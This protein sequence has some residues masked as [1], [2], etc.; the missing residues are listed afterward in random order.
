MYPFKIGM[1]F[2]D[3]LRQI[4]DRPVA[5]DGIGDAAANIFPHLPITID[6][7]GVDGLIRFGPGLPDEPFYLQELSFLP[8]DKSFVVN[9]IMLYQA[10]RLCR[11]HFYQK[12]HKDSRV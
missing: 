6:Q 3:E 7:F 11:E 4:V 5:P 2:F 12:T 1:F 9:E 8:H 10:Y